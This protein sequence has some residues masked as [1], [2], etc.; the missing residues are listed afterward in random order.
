[1]QEI[2]SVQVTVNYIRSL[3][4]D[5]PLA[6]IESDG[7]LRYYHV[8]ALG[9][10]IALSDENGVVM[11][12]Y[13][14]DPFGNVVVSGEASD[15]PFQYTGRENDG[16][17]LY[18]YRFRYYSP[19]LQRF[20]SEDPIGFLGGVNYYSYVGN[21]PVN[22]VD[23][24]GL[25]VLYCNRGAHG[26]LGWVGF[27]HGYLWDTETGDYYG[28]GGSE[29][30]GPDEDTCAEVPGTEGLESA[31]LN[32]LWERSEEPWRPW[33]NCHTAIDDV[34]TGYGLIDHPEPPGGWW[35]PIPD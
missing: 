10:V 6:R 9:S 11:T 19:E 3:N 7:T 29:E 28:M 25:I 22:W 1:V 26:P 8:D 12:T 2:E 4:I 23:P 34:L 30:L 18:Y 24:W 16:T 14:Y 15:N 17:G 13:A 5:E 20:I 27:N 21:D 31:I 35:G 32:K 33:S